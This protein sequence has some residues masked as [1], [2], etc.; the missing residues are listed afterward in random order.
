MAPEGETFVGYE[1]ES[2]D[3]QKGMEMRPD[4]FVTYFYIQSAFF[5]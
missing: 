4:I 1:E 3:E 5:L 2:S